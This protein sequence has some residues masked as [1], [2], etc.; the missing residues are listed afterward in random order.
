MSAA[1]VTTLPVDARFSGVLTVDSERFH[2]ID[3]PDLVRIRAAA[4]TS[5]ADG[6]IGRNA[7]GTHADAKIEPQL[8]GRLERTNSYGAIV[9]IIR[10]STEDVVRATL[11][12]FTFRGLL[13]RR[14]DFAL[15]AVDHDDGH[16]P[17]R[18]AAGVRELWAQSGAKTWEDC[19]QR[20]ERILAWMREAGQP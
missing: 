2:V 19:A 11:T 1:V 8:F 14:L 15:F 7:W 16:G 20:R 9:D 5:G 3:S 17:Q 13:N 12:D 18:V 6:V 10:R 4:W